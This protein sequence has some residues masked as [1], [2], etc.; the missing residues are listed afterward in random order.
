MKRDRTNYSHSEIDSNYFPVSFPHVDDAE[1]EAIVADADPY[2]ISSDAWAGPDNPFN[3]FH[4]ADIGYPLC[5][6]WRDDAVGRLVIYDST[7]DSAW[8]ECGEQDAR[9]RHEWC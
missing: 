9:Q 2:D 3:P 6:G 7:N 4:T 8:I 1:I 5:S